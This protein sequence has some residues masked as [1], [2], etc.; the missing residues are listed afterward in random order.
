MP[1][2]RSSWNGIPRLMRSFIST[3]TAV[4]YIHIT[5]DYTINEDMLAMDWVFR[6]N[7][8]VDITCHGYDTLKCADLNTNP[9]SPM[10]LLPHSYVT[11]RKGVR[12]NN[13][14]LPCMINVLT[15]KLSSKF[16][17]Y[18]R[19]SCIYFNFLHSQ[20]QF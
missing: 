20:L 19:F 17:Y 1:L 7:L 9:V 10:T 18:R 13:F 4:Q 6:Y 11:V 8:P 16:C 5:L 14:V 2:L 15:L 12:I 3:F